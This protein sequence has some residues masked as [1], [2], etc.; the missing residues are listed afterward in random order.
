[1]PCVKGHCLRQ[2]RCFASAHLQQR[3]IRARAESPEDAQP[4]HPR[5]QER[6]DEI[7]AE[8]KYLLDFIRAE[9]APVSADPLADASVIADCIKR[10]IIDAPHIV[11]NERFTGTLQ[12]RVIDGKC[13]AW[14][15]ENKVAMD[16]RTR[17]KKLTG[18]EIGLEAAG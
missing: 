7:K 13:L 17:L 11:K 16:E 2:S 5:V 3:E 12:T 15:G 6:R 4:F 9:Y 1:M 10:G 14:D 8:V 18:K